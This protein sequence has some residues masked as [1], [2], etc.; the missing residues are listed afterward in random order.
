MSRG[1]YRVVPGL[2]PRS[3]CLQSPCLITTF[4]CM[5]SSLPL[6]VQCRPATQ[7]VMRKTSNLP[8]LTI[9]TVAFHIHY[10]K[11]LLSDRMTHRSPKH[12]ISSTEKKPAGS[13]IK[14]IIAAFLWCWTSQ[15]SQPNRWGRCLCRDRFTPAQHLG[16]F[17]WKE[18]GLP[19]LLQQN[20][21]FLGNSQTW[22]WADAL[23]EPL[24]ASTDG[25]FCIEI[26]S[27]LHNW[28]T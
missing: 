5:P 3:T 8:F 7:Q 26:A 24:N 2:K 25:T 9:V 28:G 4:P 15:N 6:V 1:Q 12:G 23:T 27:K 13:L 11:Y 19:G 17:L 10:F 21:L 14:L 16:G 18:L 22:Q 20:L